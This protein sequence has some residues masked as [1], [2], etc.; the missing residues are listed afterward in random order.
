[1]LGFRARALGAELAPCLDEIEDAQWFT[2]KELRDA[3]RTGFPKVPP[4]GLSIAGRL[5]N[6]WLDEV[7]PA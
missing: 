6:D 3:T 5:L 7:A 1:M 4:R 2:A